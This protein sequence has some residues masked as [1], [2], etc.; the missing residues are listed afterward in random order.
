VNW[1][2]IADL[3]AWLTT[4]GVVSVP[5][6]VGPDGRHHPAVY[7]WSEVKSTI[8]VNQNTQGLSVITGSASRAVC[9]DIDPRNGGNE[10]WAELGVEVPETLT[11]HTPGRGVHYYFRLPEGVHAGKRVHGLGRGVDLLGTGA[12]PT[13]SGTRDDGTFYAVERHPLAVCPEWL[14]PRLP[15]GSSE[16]PQAVSEPP[17][18]ADTCSAMARLSSALR[19]DAAGGDRIE[20]LTALRRLAKAA[21]DGHTGFRQAVADAGPVYVGA[22]AAK[23]AYD[24]GNRAETA[25][26]DYVGLVKTVLRGFVQGDKDPC[27][28]YSAFAALLGM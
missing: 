7:Q 14:V 6:R 20:T 15:G 12:A 1:R 27:D 8:H 17:V 23:D 16:G 21:R 13:I 25:G 2:D 3:Q 9:V 22:R 11:V 24:G 19:Q 26:D 10:T 5:A 18:T 4:Q 28:G